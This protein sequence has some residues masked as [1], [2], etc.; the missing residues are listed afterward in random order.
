MASPPPPTPRSGIATVS[1]AAGRYASQGMISPVEPSFVDPTTGVLAPVSFRF[2]YGLYSDIQALQQQVAQLQSVLAA[3]QFSASRQTPS[4]PT[5]STG[6]AI[7]LGVGISFTAPAGND[8]AFVAI[9][10]QMG[11]ANAGSTA[12]AVLSWGTGALPAPG[13]SPGNILSQLISYTSPTA[14]AQ[15]PFSESGIVSGLVAGTQY[16]VDLVVG[17]SGGGNSNVT[18][19]DLNVFGLVEAGA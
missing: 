18:S 8:R 1:T 10:G 2:L 6:G 19:I 15:T 17:C 9:D 7:T 5:Q 12:L 14:N 16:W 13:S 3:G 4:P 11:A